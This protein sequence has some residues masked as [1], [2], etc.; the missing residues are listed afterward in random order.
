MICGTGLTYK[1]EAVALRCHYC[2]REFKSNI[3][4]TRGHAICEEC[5]NRS[6]VSFAK[7]VFRETFSKD[8][9]YIF[10]HII[11]EFPVSMLGCHHAFMVGAAVLGAIKNVGRLYNPEQALEEVFN[12]IER[13]AIGGYCGLTGVCGITVAVGACFSWLLGARCG[14]DQEQKM[15]MQVTS[16]VSKLIYE[17]T[18]PSC[19]KAYSWKAI[20]CATMYLEQYLKICLEKSSAEIKCKFQ[21]LHP[22]GCRGTLCPYH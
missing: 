3:Y 4:C 19:C 9:F 21:N 14:M 8:P 13:Q 12:R 7:K 5:H 16:D 2:G 18:G 11:E 6:C 10:N 1:S 17:L 20:E 22:H 15:V